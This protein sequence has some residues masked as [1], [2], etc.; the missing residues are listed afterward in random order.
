MPA[1]MEVYATQLFN[2]ET[3]LTG[4]EELMEAVPVHWE[5]WKARGWMMLQ[6]AGGHHLNC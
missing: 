2:Q 6:T 4:V 5:Q 3:D 1:L